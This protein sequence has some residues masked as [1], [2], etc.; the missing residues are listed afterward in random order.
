[1]K[2]TMELLEFQFDLEFQFTT[3]LHRIDNFEKYF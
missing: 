3:S 1:M 2:D